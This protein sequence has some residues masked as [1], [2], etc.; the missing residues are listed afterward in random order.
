[1]LV[2]GYSMIYRIVI[3]RAPT[4]TTIPSSLR[5]HVQHCVRIATTID[6]RRSNNDRD[7]VCKFYICASFSNYCRLVPSPFYATRTVYEWSTNIQS[8]FA[9]DWAREVGYIGNRGVHMD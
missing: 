3:S 7:D 1:M 2:L 6:Q 4:S 9:R 5:P 8:Q